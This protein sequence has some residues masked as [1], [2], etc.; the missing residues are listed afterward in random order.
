MP[1]FA[2]LKRVVSI[3]DKLRIPYL[4]TGSLASSA[5]GDPR[6]THDIDLVIEISQNSV[7]EFLLNFPLDSFYYDL[8]AARDAIQKR[9]MFNLIDSRQGQKVDFYIL[10]FDDYE[11]VRFGRRIKES[12]ADSAMYMTAPEDTIISKLRW[13]NKSNFSQKHFTDATAV[14]MCQK[15]ILDMAYIGEWTARLGLH[16]LWATLRHKADSSGLN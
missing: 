10:P 4:I 5:Q 2:L 12:I 6:L 8:S 15:E 11:Q 7:Q 3:L 14:Y 9:S 13:C 16:E 1:Q